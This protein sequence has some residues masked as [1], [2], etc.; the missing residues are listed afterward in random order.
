M[1]ALRFRLKKNRRVNLEAGTFNL[2]TAKTYLGR[3]IEKAGKGEVIYIV[4]G[5]QRFILQEVPT[6]D[7]IPMRPSGYFA[8]CYNK[9]ELR[10]ENHL[11]KRSVV[12]PPRDLE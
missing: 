12:K 7:P 4:R 2:S 3:L 10:E 11:A 6:I 9:A 1:E 8:N 5:Q